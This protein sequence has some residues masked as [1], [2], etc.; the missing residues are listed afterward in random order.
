MAAKKGRQAP[1]VDLDELEPS[2]A[3]VDFETFLEEVGAGASVVDIYRMNRDGTRSHEERI[4]FQALAADVFGYLRANYG[5]G[6]YLLLFR[7][8][9]RR[10]KGSKV[11]SIGQGPGAPAPQQQ[12][13]PHGQPSDHVQFMREQMAQQQTMMTAILGAMKPPDLTPIATAIISANKPQDPAAMLTAVTAVFTALKGPAKDEDWLDRAGKIITLAKGLQ[14][15][16]DGGD[17]NVFTVI[18]EVA[19]DWMDLQRGGAPYTPPQN[20]GGERRQ[21]AAANGGGGQQQA[22]A[23]STEVNE[24]VTEQTFAQWIR[25]GLA[26]LKDKAKRGKDIETILDYMFENHEEPQFNALLGAVQRG[27]TFENVLQFD[28]EIGK[29][30]DLQQ[31]FRALYDGIQTELQNQKSMDSAGQAGHS[32]NPAT[33]EGGG[34]GGPGAAGG[35]G[36][37]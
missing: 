8:E 36:A 32:D 4:E 12:A 3:E 23:A 25:T 27:A 17:D 33:H 21:I 24:Q 37:G 13:A 11:V 18:K 16:G 26:Y 20:G 19:K 22:A 1:L 31:W 28:P 6:K 7:D 10:F 2:Q 14:P 29:N 35:G 5:P 9:H 15:G 34:P 30:P